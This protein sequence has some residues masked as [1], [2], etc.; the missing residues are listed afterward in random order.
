MRFLDLAGLLAQAELEELFAGLAEL[1]GDLGWREG[2]DFF[3]GHGGDF[4]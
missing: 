2:A 1:G 3:G 4:C